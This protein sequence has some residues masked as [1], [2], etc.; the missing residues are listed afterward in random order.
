MDSLVKEII[1][2]LY[3]FQVSSLFEKNM[4]VLEKLLVSK[5]DKMV[6]YLEIMIPTML[7]FINNEDNVVQE[8][9]YNV[10]NIIRQY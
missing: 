7:E 1:K 10:L 6:L 5:N 9:S 2:S 3:E 4:N 8:V